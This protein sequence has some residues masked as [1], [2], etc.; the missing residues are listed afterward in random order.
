[1]FLAGR[2]GARGAGGGGRGGDSAAGRGA[3]APRARPPHGVPAQRRHT[4][5]RVL[6]VRCVRDETEYSSVLTAQLR[7]YSH[8]HQTLIGTQPS[9][10]FNGFK[11]TFYQMKS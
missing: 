4:V 2:V 3:R 10:W 9:K 5:P 8:W 11:T 1:M 6:H 7:H